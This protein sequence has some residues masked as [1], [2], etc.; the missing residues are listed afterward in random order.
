MV[1]GTHIVD[2]VRVLETL[3]IADALF[4]FYSLF[5]ISCNVKHSGFCVS[6]FGAC[7]IQYN[8]TV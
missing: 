3:L 5:G 6:V 8:S 4:T 7:I 2:S 1:F